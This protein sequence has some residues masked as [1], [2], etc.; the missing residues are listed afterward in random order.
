MCDLVTALMIG[1]T[2]M[3]GVSS[4]QQ[5]NA[6]AAAGRYNAQVAEMNAKIADNNARDAL[7]R[8]K[9]EEQ[10]KRREVSMLTGRQRAAMAANGVDLSF[11]SPLDTLV[12][13]AML[14][15]LDALTIRSNSAREAYNYKVNAENS[16]ADGRLSLANAKAAKTGGYLSAMGTV[17]GGAGDVGKYRASLKT[18]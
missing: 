2:V 1:S 8:G 4:I 14:G 15:E 13:T 18:M 5:G 17:L 9:I 16:R 10:N 7:E 6:Q 11:G 12:D 3:G